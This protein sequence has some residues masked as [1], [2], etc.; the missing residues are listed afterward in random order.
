MMDSRETHIC[1]CGYSTGFNA[2][3]GGT[4]ERYTLG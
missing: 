1:G 4:P 3:C 2:S